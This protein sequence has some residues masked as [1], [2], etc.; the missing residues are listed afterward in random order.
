MSSSTPAEDRE[1]VAAHINDRGLPSPPSAEDINI[2]TTI[3]AVSDLGLDDSGGSAVEST[4]NSAATSGT[5]IT[6]PSG[7]YRLGGQIAVSASNV[8]LVGDG[9]ATFVV[10]SGIT[11]NVVRFNGDS[12]VG[13]RNFTI[14]Q[15]ADDC[16]AQTAF[17]ISD[18][19]VVEDIEF[20]GYS[21]PDDSGKK[22][23]PQIQ[24]SSGSGVVRRCVMT[25]G[26]EVGDQSVSH[27]DTHK[28]Q[29]DGGFWAGPDHIGTVYIFDCQAA[30]WSDNALYMSRTN[31]GVVVAGGRYANSSIS[32]VRVSHEDSFV[33]GG[34]FIEID[35]DKIPSQNNPS[36]LASARGIWLEPGHIYG[37]QG[38]VIG[39][40]HFRM[41]SNVP[42]VP[43]M[44]MAGRAYGDT[45]IVGPCD[46]EINGDYRAI[47]A[48]SPDGGNRDAPPTPH[49]FQ[50]ENLT[51]VG[52]SSV[53]PALIHIED[54]P[55][56]SVDGAC[57]SHPSTNVQG[58]ETSNIS[59]S[60]CSLRDPGEFSTIGFDGFEGQTDSN[61]MVDVDVPGGE[62]VV[63]VTHPDTDETLE[64]TL[65]VQSDEDVTMSFTDVLT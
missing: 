44:I 43:G 55:D 16:S 65:T 2:S 35:K 52:D 9:D 45:T 63:V 33:G 38:V 46:F 24:S 13:F 18:G 29:Y 53:S 12:N 42:N 49:S 20:A 47:Y 7:T 6:F 64:Q 17:N 15:S 32:Q 54:R 56:S 21:D 25:D 10:D 28:Q 14:D 37:N 5:R 4:I 50:M 58:A 62:Y 41:G 48:R 8:D 61:G 30:N 31:G 40:C 22:L 59:T 27:N 11:G 19:L 3:D 26:T 60:G 51:I 57:I 34:V 36:G 1:D 23:V 39:N